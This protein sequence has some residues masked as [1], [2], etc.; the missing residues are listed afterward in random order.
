MTTGSALRLLGLVRR[1]SSL[2]FATALFAALFAALS[3]A[4][5]AASPKEASKHFSRGVA[6]YNE[7]DYRAALVEFKRA[8]DLAP[9]PSVL[10][11][12]GQTYFQLQNYAAALTTFERYLAESPAGAAHRS[13]V[14]QSV[15]TLR[16]RVGK[17]DVKTNVPGAEISIDDEPVGKTPLEKPL[18][19]SIGRRKITATI[20]GQPAQTRNVEIAAEETARLTL[21][22]GG[23]GAE[24]GA[25]GAGA[26]ARKQPS[27]GASRIR[28]GWITTGVLGAGALVMGGLAFKASRD[29]DSM[30]TS[31]PVTRD[32]LDDKASSLKTFS[33]A[34]DVLG[35]AALAVGGVTL[36]FKM[37]RGTAR[38]R[39]IRAGLA[40]RGLQLSGTF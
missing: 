11:N 30:R 34:A 12:I 2:L 9:N 25:G 40:P 21:T 20:D 13:E 18:R 6:L 4:P 16:S 7:A 29:L 14:E 28:I 8:Y 35:V 22:F 26:G 38:P 1:A 36:Y 24:A 27:S 19:V 5:A 10:Y 39:E 17:L 23:A 37:T 33:L 32:G 31:F 15:E 3:A